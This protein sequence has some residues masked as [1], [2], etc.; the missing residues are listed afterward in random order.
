MS[1]LIDQYGTP[2]LDAQSIDDL[3]EFWKETNSV[4]PI[5]FARRLFPDRPKG[6]VAVTRDIGCYA[7]N[8]ATAMKCR[9]EGKIQIAIQYEDICERIYQ[10]LPQWAKW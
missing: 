4:R 3:W 2:N 6:Y 9:L 7:S 8:R 10:R 5:R 1:N